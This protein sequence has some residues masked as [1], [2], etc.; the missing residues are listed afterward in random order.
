M[1]KVLM[2]LRVILF[3]IVLLLTAVLSYLLTAVYTV[4]TYESSDRGMAEIEVPGKGRTL[5]QVEGYFEKYK[6]W[7]NDD[8][9]ILY[10]TCKRNWLNPWLWREN[11]T[12][13][14]WKYLYMEPSKNPN[15]RYF[16]EYIK[17]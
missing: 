9:L 5:E 1:K 6:K 12:H 14:R 17:K 8:S 2:T 13:R 15:T 10:R 4:Y 3:I 16:M 11:I 7:K